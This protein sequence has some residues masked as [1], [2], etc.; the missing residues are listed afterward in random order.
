MLRIFGH[1]YLKQGVEPAAQELRR[2]KPFSE[3]TVSPED[4]NHIE[5]S[6][7]KISKIR[8]VSTAEVGGRVNQIGY[9]V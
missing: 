8:R 1:R 2:S 5:R 4:T 6:R 3:V 7:T 9:G